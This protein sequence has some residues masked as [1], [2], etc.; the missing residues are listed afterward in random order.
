MGRHAKTVLTEDGLDR[1]ETGYYSTPDFV[2]KF[3]TSALMEVN[4]S[5]THALDPCVGRGELVDYF[6]R[7]GRDITGMDIESHPLQLSGEIDFVKADFLQYFSERVQNPLFADNF[8]SRFD[9]YIAN[10]PYNCHEVDYIRKNRLNLESAFAAVG[11]HNLYAMFVYAMIV[12][13][14]EGAAI[15]FI[16]LDSFLNS[17]CYA[18]L[19]RVIFDLCSIHY[20]ILCPNDLFRDQKADVRTCL[21]ILQKGRRFQNRVKVSDRPTS[22]AQ[23]R[24]ILEEE[25][26]SEVSL[27]QI[28]LNFELDDD[29]F[30]VGC[31]DEVKN[32]FN[33]PRL[34]QMFKCFTGISTGND[35]AYLRKEK[36]SGFSVPFYKNPGSRRFYTE[37]DG[38][39]C[40]N[41]LDVGQR[42]KNFMV[43]NRDLIGKEGITCSSMG[44]PFT[45]CFRPEGSAIGVNA[46]ILCD[47]KD[48]IWWLI[49]FLNSSLA[50]YIVRGCLLRTNMI[51]SGYVSRIPVPRFSSETKQTLG[52]LAKN[53]YVNRLRPGEYGKTTAAIDSVIFNDVQLLPNTRL[54]VQSFASNIILRT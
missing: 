8:F 29:E 52:S 30:I 32:L 24:Q 7:L 23:F 15:G 5:G 44:V 3:M 33:L 10:P 19:R 27:S 22:K 13:A 26:F 36:E 43:R 11:V 50:T 16:T 47:D 38:F 49:A 18:A 17:N 31:P 6:L 53:A 9:Y 25:L 4:P 14:R 34:G 46:N 2:A 39:L 28:T 21:M 42:V 48:D 40:D 41:F 51:T 20:L 12:S 35:E 1:R 37:P 45:A 54:F